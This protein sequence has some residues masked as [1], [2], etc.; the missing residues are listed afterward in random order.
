M[1]KRVQF[2]DNIRLSNMH[3][4]S[5]RSFATSKRGFGMF[6]PQHLHWYLLLGFFGLTA[7]ELLLPEEQ[8]R[9]S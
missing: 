6:H 9:G 2:N 3:P 7:A 5:G 8:G 4:L 1:I